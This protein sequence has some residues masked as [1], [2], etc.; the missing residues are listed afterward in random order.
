MLRLQIK[1]PRDSLINSRHALSYSSFSMLT[2]TS[3]VSPP[4]CSFTSSV[5]KKS[6]SRLSSV[7]SWYKFHKLVRADRDSAWTV[8]HTQP[9]VRFTRLVPAGRT[10]LSTAVT[11]WSNVVQRLK[12]SMV[13][14]TSTPPPTTLNTVLMFSTEEI[15]EQQNTTLYRVSDTFREIFVWVTR[16]ESANNNITKERKG[17][18]GGTW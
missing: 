10:H 6:Y 8:R 5:T 15:K 4:A 9:S 3:T 12:T 13:E 16:V 1:L 17:K 2:F 18:G 11:S 7:P 14:T